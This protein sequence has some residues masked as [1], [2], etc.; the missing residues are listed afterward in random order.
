MQITNIFAHVFEWLLLRK[1][2]P[3]C[4]WEEL[5]R[6]KVHSM[7]GSTIINVCNSRKSQR[8]QKIVIIFSLSYFFSTMKLVSGNL[9]AARSI[10]IQNQSQWLKDV[11]WR[12]L[13]HSSVQIVI[14]KPSIFCNY[15]HLFLDYIKG[16]EFHDMLS[17]PSCANNQ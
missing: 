8:C 1:R 10:A 7:L 14:Q 9:P 2:P 16:H 15:G 5:L 13:H 17:H 12:A 6:A 11:H 4:F 3:C